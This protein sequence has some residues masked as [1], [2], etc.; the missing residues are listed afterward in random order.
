VKEINEFLS[1]MFTNPAICKYVKDIFA[2]TIDGGIRHEK[3]YIF[4]GSGCHAVDTPI[5]MYD[6]T[7][8]KV[9]DIQEGDMLMGDDHTPRTVKEL[10]RGVD[11]MYTICPTKGESF[12]VN[13]NHVLTLQ[14][15]NL[16]SIVQ[17]NDGYYKENP[18]LP[19]S[20]V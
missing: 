6:G 13:Q 10:F 3:F 17:R 12:Q 4:T 5:L 1:Q 7:V 15:T 9:Q 14:F 19:R 11:E 8:K 16:V 20:M 2:S 18:Q